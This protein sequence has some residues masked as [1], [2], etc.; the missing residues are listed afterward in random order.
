MM[1]IVIIHFFGCVKTVQYYRRLIS[2]VNMVQVYCAGG[3]GS[4]PGRTNTRGLNKIV[5]EKV[6]PLP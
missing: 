3:S 5:E 4:I 2:L 1:Q 6:L